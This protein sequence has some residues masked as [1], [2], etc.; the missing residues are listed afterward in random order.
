M[1]ASHWSKKKRPRKKYQGVRNQS[2][3]F[4][5]LHGFLFVSQS[6]RYILQHHRGFFFGGGRGDN[7]IPPSW[8]LKLPE[9]WD[10]SKIDFKGAGC[11]IDSKSFVYDK[12]L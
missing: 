11:D 10:E 9:N 1:R 3:L 8:K 2:S 12:Y 5:F 4:Y 7:T 6:Y